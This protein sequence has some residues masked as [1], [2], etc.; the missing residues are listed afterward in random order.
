MWKTDHCGPCPTCR[1][2]WMSGSSQ[3]RPYDALRDPSAPARRCRYCCWAR[4]V[5]P[6]SVEV[7]QIDAPAPVAGVEDVQPDQGRGVLRRGSNLD[8]RQGPLPE[9]QIRRLRA[10][11]RQFH[12]GQVVERLVAQ[13]AHRRLDLSEADPSA[14]TQLRL[15]PA[16]HLRHNRRRKIGERHHLDRRVGRGCRQRPSL[17]VGAPGLGPLPLV[18]QAQPALLAPRP[19]V[20]TREPGTSR[21]LGEARDPG[22]GTPRR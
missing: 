17:A 7:P 2:C 6:G 14:L 22:R 19:C 13:P 1:T 16:Q 9:P 4:C 3:N 8:E 15:V 11:G 10:L 20:G 21:S 5:T 12:G 18:R